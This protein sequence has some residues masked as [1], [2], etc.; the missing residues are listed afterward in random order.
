VTEVVD[1]CLCVFRCAA[2]FISPFLLDNLILFFCSSNLF[3][4]FFPTFFALSVI[5]SQLLDFHLC[6]W[7]FDHYFYVLPSFRRFPIFFLA[8][9]SHI[10]SILS[11]VHSTFAFDNLILFFFLQSFTIFP[12]FFGFYQSYS[13]SCLF[14]LCWRQFDPFFCSSIFRS[15]FF[16]LIRVI[17]SQLLI[18]TFALTIWVLFFVLQSFFSVVFPYW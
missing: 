16:C 8:L 4:S 17:F 6:F 13:F 10:L 7:Q 1:W 5:F 12:I 14:H 18:F 3:P 11:I 9:S 2:S 15:T